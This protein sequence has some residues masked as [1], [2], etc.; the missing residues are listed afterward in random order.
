MDKIEF[1]PCMEAVEIWKKTFIDEKRDLDE[2]IEEVK[3][4]ID[5]ERVFQLGSST[6]DE[7]MMHEQ[8]IVDSL[9]Y[10]DWLLSQK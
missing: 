5:N 6:E 8:N 9:E 2:E 3:G 7:V 1:S 10:L 4:A